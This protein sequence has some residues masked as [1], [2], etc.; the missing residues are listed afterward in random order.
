MNI[1]RIKKYFKRR[2]RRWRKAIWT[3]S[4]CG[5]VAWLAWL[6]TPLSGQLEAVM[7]REEP[8]VLETLADLQT[9]SEQVPSKEFR[10]A[11]NDIDRVR[12]VHLNKIYTCGEESQVLGN[13]NGKEIADLQNKHP[14]WTGHVD[15]EGHVWFDHH[16]RDLSDICK[17]SGYIGLDSKGNL[18]LF[19][20]PPKDEK[21]M[22]T[23]FQL[24]I[25]SMESAL[26]KEVVYQLKQGIRIE[27]VEEYNS[28]L[29]TF[30]DYATTS[31]Q[32]VMKLN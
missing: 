1:F 28:V 31:S 4:A 30:S 18:S 24:D 15:R 22:R 8:A 23:F 9:A 20:G 21:V 29:S 32:K 6:G 14:D 27:D 3:I 11:I 25:E 7:T 10:Q 19:E 17:R 2:W 5:I 12:T 13:L 16:I 26:P